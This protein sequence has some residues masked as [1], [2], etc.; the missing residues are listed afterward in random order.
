MKHTTILAQKKTP[1]VVPPEFIERGCNHRGPANLRSERVPDSLLERGSP[2]FG[3][4]PKNYLSSPI[5]Y[6]IPA[7]LSSAR[8]NVEHPP[9]PFPRL[10]VR[11]CSKNSVVQLEKQEPCRFNSSGSPCGAAHTHTHSLSLS[12]TRGPPP[13]ATTAAEER[14]DHRHG[15]PS[16]GYPARP[17]G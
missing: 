13:L 4:P 14:V 2:C 9:P 16:R 10:L 8:P 5:L 15:R 12:C 11:A 7:P 1:L 17:Y 6:P 3:S